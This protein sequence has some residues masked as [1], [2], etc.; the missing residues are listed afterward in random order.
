MTDTRSNGKY[1]RLFLILNPE[2][3]GYNLSPQKLLGNVIIEVRDGQGRL[4]LSVQGL[5]EPKNAKYQLM[6]VSKNNNSN[7]GVRLAHVMPDKRGKVYESWAFDPNNVGGSKIPIDQFEATVI[8]TDSALPRDFV[9]IMAGYKD[10]AFDWRNGLS[11]FEKNAPKPPEKKLS[12]PSDSVPK[13]VETSDSEMPQIEQPTNDTEQPSEDLPG[14]P[15]IPQNNGEINLPN[16]ATLYENPDTANDMDIVVPENDSTH[17]EGEFFNN[18]GS[19]PADSRYCKC[20]PKD[21]VFN[22]LNDDSTFTP[23]PKVINK[24]INS[25]VE[26]LKFKISQILNFPQYERVETFLDGVSD[27]ISGETYDPLIKLLNV[28]IDYIPGNQY[29]HLLELVGDLVDFDDSKIGRINE[30]I[31]IIRQYVPPKV[32]EG[33]VDEVLKIKNGMTEPQHEEF[34]MFIDGIIDMMQFAEDA[35]IPQSADKSNNLEQPAPE[36]EF[37][38]V[39]EMPNYGIESNSFEQ[40]RDTNV[41]Y[42]V[43]SDFFEEPCGKRQ[44]AVDE[45]DI[46]FRGVLKGFQQEFEDIEKNMRET[47]LA[48]DEYERAFGSDTYS[49]D[50]AIDYLYKSRPPMNPFKKPYKGVRWIRVTLKDITALPIKIWKYTNNPFVNLAYKKH[51][52]LLFGIGGHNH[53]R[54]YYLGVPGQ[55]DK[56]QKDAAAYLGFDNFLSLSSTLPQPRD[57]GY[58]VKEL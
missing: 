9:S 14:E 36:L 29:E 38:Q 18:D 47:Q 31:Q 52:H 26:Q 21:N 51:K 55:Y 41:P 17:N 15:D 7:V 34:K 3:G 23:K 13:S 28:M 53:R 42:A 24:M 43:A 8:S 35:E 10:R 39:D 49:Y 16:D 6:L 46:K 37:M 33:F 58:W 19:P 54:E 22:K 57:I 40:L 32:F 20:N 45:A 4:T 2:A 48:S 1:Q 56:K 44:S 12:E 25:A 27:N 11:V 30:I 5:K 50:D